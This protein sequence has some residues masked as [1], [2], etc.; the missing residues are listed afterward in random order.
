MLP[1]YCGELSS[2]IGIEFENSLAVFEQNEM[3][4]EWKPQSK[5]PRGIYLYS[6]IDDAVYVV[7]SIP[8]NQFPVNEIY[9]MVNGKFTRNE[10]F[11]YM[12]T[13]IG[14]NEYERFA[15]LIRTGVIEEKCFEQ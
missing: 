3:I 9:L 12:S 8:H 11:T 6:K 4:D 7:A 10:E 5:I 14:I 1:V 13:G 15:E 2:E